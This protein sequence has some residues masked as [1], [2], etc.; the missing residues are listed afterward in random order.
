MLMKYFEQMANK[1]DF[2]RLI[3]THTHVE[4]V[5]GSVVMILTESYN[6][7]NIR[8][9]AK[10]TTWWKTEFCDSLDYETTH[11]SCTK[12]KRDILPSPVSRDSEDLKILR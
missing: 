5:F 10:E 9:H 1:K 7:I 11:R 2:L 8:D 4:Q 3:N 6:F 12:N